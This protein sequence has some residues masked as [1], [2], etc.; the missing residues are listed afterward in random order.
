MSL[1]NYPLQ[2]TTQVGAAGPFPIPIRSLWSLVDP[3]GPGPPGGCA[4]SSGT[5]AP[6][7]RGCGHPLPGG[8]LGPPGGLRPPPAILGA[9]D[10]PGSFAAELRGPF[11]TPSGPLVVEL[12]GP[13]GTPPGP[14]RGPS[15]WSFGSPSGPLVVELCGPFGT[16]S[17]PLVVELRGPFGTPRGPLGTPSEWSFAGPSGPPRDPS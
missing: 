12:R 7:P 3:P 1:L 8:L 13:F 14:P 6:R 5:V 11:G 16:P 4:W 9:S 15:Q 17:G 10:P 2:D